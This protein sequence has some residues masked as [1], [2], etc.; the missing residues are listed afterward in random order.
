MRTYEIAVYPKSFGVKNAGGRP[1]KWAFWGGKNS[2]GNL[3]YPFAK[4][5]EDCHRICQEFIK[6]QD[7]PEIWNYFIFQ[8]WETDEQK[9]G[10]TVPVEEGRSVWDRERRERK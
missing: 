1:P 4:D 10:T 3:Y 8:Y 5:I 2:N 6:E 7:D 9:R